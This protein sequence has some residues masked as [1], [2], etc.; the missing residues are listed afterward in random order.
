MK[1]IFPVS[2]I[3][4]SL[5]HLTG[6]IP[7]TS[8]QVPSTAIPEIFPD[9]TYVTVPSTIAPLNFTPQDTFYTAVIAE[10]SGTRGNLFRVKGRKNIT[11]PKNKWTELLNANKGDSISVTLKI[12][13]EDKWIQHTSFP[14]YISEHPIDHGLVYRLIAP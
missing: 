12:L 3:L 9:Y 14:I 5:L 8:T 10:F 6:C 13:K 11:I 7:N 4:I 2:L 1:R